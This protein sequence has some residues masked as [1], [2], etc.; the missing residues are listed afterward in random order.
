MCGN[1]NTQQGFKRYPALKERFYSVV[2]AF[3][4]KAMIPTNKL[5]SDLVAAE[6]TYINTGHPDFISGHKAMA[7][8][9]AKIEA[10][11]PP[12]PSGPAVLDKTGK[13]PPGAINNGRDLDVDMKQDP[14]F[15]GSF[16]K[17]GQ[18]GP[19]RKGAAG[20]M[21]PPPQSLKASGNLSEREMIETDVIK[22][23]SSFPLL[24]PSST[25]LVGESHSSS[26]LTL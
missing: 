25:L 8:V 17:G 11:K 15:F 19:R 10:A 22:R 16:W 26:M 24:P 3:Y 14:G 2:V 12:P 21:E 7:L 18:P 23:S 6:A 20:L 4:K 9:N 5:V 1:G 13:L